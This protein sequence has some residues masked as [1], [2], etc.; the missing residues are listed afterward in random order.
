MKDADSPASGAM[1]GMNRVGVS[2]AVPNRP[3]RPGLVTVVEPGVCS[4]AAT[5]AGLLAVMSTIRL[6]MVRG[7]ESITVPLVCV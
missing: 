4:A 3:S 5:A 6:L 1:F 7:W 2:S